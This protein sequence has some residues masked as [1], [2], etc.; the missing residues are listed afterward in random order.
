MNRIEELGLHTSVEAKPILDVSRV[1]LSAIDVD[2]IFSE[3]YQ[4]RQV[5][6]AMGASKPGPWTGQILARVIEWQLEHPDGTMVECEAWLRAEREA[7][8]IRIEENC[9]ADSA[10]KRTKASGND[11]ATKKAKR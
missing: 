1:S 9:V 10:G 6:E 2:F 7:G 5:N 3:I 8:R 4:G 11:P